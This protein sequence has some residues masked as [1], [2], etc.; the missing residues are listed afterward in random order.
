[1]KVVIDATCLVLNPFSGLSEVVHN[2]LLHLPHV[3]ANNQFA[4]FMNYFRSSNPKTEVFYPGTVNQVCRVPR[5][6]MAWWW[7]FNKPSID[8]YL[9]GTDIYHSL[10]IQIPPTKQIKTVLTVHDCRYLA[11]PELYMFQEIEKYRQQMST[12]LKRVDMVTTVSEF[13]RQ[14]VIHHFSFPKDRIRMI[15][16]GFTPIQIEE[17][18]NQ[19]KIKRFIENKNLPKSYLL[20]AGVLDPRKNIGRLIEAIAQCRMETENFPE[21]LIAG[22]SFGDWARSK[23]GARAKELGIFDY[24]HLCGA[25]EKDILAGLIQKAHVLCYPS[26]YEGFGFPPLEAMSLG[27][28]VL[29]GKSSSIPE[30]VGLAA[31]LVDPLNVEEIAQGLHKVVFDSD[32]RREIID[33]GYQQINN[34]SWRKAAREYINLYKDVIH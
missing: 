16:N 33:L 9:K 25:V 21:L 17:G 27:V 20:Y 1:M 15:H 6:L 24:I 8:L 12:S 13:T 4:L 31:C 11:H 19:E 10:H 34:Y 32:Y 29:A 30:I 3:D 22:I 5:K 7:K 28:P 2:L 14:E 18:H 23:Y 26:L